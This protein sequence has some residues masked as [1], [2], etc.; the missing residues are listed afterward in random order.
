VGSKEVTSQKISNGGSVF[1]PTAEAEEREVYSSLDVEARKEL[2]TYTS[3]SNPPQ[4]MY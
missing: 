1:S 4:G 2:S 3:A